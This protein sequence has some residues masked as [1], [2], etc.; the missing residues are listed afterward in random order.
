MDAS[1]HTP[2]LAR[3][4]R[5]VWNPA[6]GRFDAVPSATAGR[7]VRPAKAAKLARLPSSPM[8]AAS[9]RQALASF[10]KTISLAL[11]S[12]QPP[13]VQ[14]VHAV[15]ARDVLARHLATVKDNPPAVTTIVDGRRDAL[16]DAV[17]PYGLIR[18]EFSYPSMI[19]EA[20]AFALKEVRRLSPRQSGKYRDAWFVMA[21]G[22]PV[23]GPDAIPPTAKRVVVT[24]DEPYSRRLEVGKD[25]AGLPFVVKVPPLFTERAAVATRRRHGQ[26]VTVSYSFVR[27]QGGKARRGELTY[28]AIIIERR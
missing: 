20:A 5:R 22:A 1:R 19:R 2:G 16:E 28:P 21:D 26:R 27:L 6:T 24:N 25:A 17:K 4:S 8:P 7:S 13:E 23:S 10:E 18:Y 11:G 15:V 9:A 3:P 12:L 14:K